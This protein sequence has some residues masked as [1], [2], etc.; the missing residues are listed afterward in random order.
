MTGSRAA[1]RH[2]LILGGTGEA[3]RLAALLAADPAFAPTSSLAGRVA[4][5]RLPE[6]R[7]RLGGFGGA[8][9]LARRLREERVDAVVDATHPFADTISA[10]AAEAARTVRL[11]LLVLRR[12]GWT[13]EPGDRWHWA[14]SV[15]DAAALLPGLG[16]RAFLTTGRGDLAA[17]TAAAPGLFLLAR[18]VDPPEPPPPPHVRVL[19][20]RGPFTVEGERALLREH[21][22]DV[23][24]TKDSGGAATAPK[25][26]AARAA[27]IPVLIVRRPPPPQAVPVVASPAAAVAWLRLAVIPGSRLEG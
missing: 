23:L 8:D 13:P 12:P 20:A 10:H 25:L 17:F 2:V 14:D 24:V 6:G 5:P 19:L 1:P 22:I 7:V 26:A 4:E 11:P 9:G 18:S 21:R 15:P 16:S 27:A 3:R